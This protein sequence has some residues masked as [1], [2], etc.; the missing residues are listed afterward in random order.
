[1]FEAC[2]SDRLERVEVAELDVDAAKFPPLQLRPQSGLQKRG[3]ARARLAA[4][5][6][7]PPLLV[8][9]RLKTFF[10]V[11][12]ALQAREDF[13]VFVTERQQAFD[14]ARLQSGLQRGFPSGRTRH[15]SRYRG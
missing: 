6:A 11:L 2:P 15:Q 9:D 3:L 8:A 4:Q 7:E 12:V 14:R 5:H 13:G 10:Q 1:M